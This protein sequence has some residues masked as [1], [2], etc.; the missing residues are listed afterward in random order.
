[1]ARA[2]AP[3][4]PP[5]AVEPEQQVEGHG[6]GELRG[7]AE[8]APLGVEVGGHHL[9]H[10]GEVGCGGDF[11]TGGAERSLLE[12]LGELGGLVDQVGAPVP[13]GVG[14]RPA[15]VD[16]GGEAVAALGREVG[17]PE[18]RLAVGGEEHRHRPPPVAGE[19][20]HHLHVDGIDVG[21][22]LPV[23]LD[24]HEQL[25]HERGGGVVLE[26]LVGHHVAPMAGRVPDREQN[27][28][29]TLSCLGEGVLAP[30]EPV[31][32]VVGVLAQVGAGLVGKSVRRC[33][34]STVPT[35]VTEDA[36]DRGRR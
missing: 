11:V 15:Q 28:N 1:M 23:H 33:H 14:H 19:A 34:R 18:E 20:L 35:S 8:P 2:S 5:S 9:A 26:A 36:G 31:H 13:P 10:G 24:V 16:E 6:L 4:S 17:P 21:S 29:V 3:L 22:L 27:G 7:L 25:V 32:R 12:R 30:R